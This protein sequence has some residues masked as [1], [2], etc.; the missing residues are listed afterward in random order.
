MRVLAGGVTGNPMAWVWCHRVTGAAVM[1]RGGW[2][3]VLVAV[4]AVVAV[5]LLVCVSGAGVVAAA[6]DLVLA[7][8]EGETYGE[9]Q[10]TGAAFGSGPA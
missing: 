3:S 5:L 7:D 10:V 2:C 4:V 6:E 1:M 8:F 9:W